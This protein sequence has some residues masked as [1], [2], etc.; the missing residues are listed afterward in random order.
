MVQ[1]VSDALEPGLAAREDNPDWM[2][3]CYEF[4]IRLQSLVDSVAARTQQ[5]AN[6]A[7]PQCFDYFQL[8]VNHLQSE[9]VMFEDL[10]LAEAKV[11]ARGHKT[12][13]VQSLMCFLSQH[14]GLQA[15]VKRFNERHP[16]ITG[17]TGLSIQHN[18]TGWYMGY[19][20]CACARASG[21]CM[22]LRWPS[23]QLHSA[24]G[25]PGPGLVTS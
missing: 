21:A 5:V 12:W 20:L 13:R 23:S 15:I 18:T 11:K 17:D 16:V 6:A 2:Q 7:M 19:D 8:V 14:P 22:P 10:P 24:A 25:G 3:H 1:A 9:L 4:V